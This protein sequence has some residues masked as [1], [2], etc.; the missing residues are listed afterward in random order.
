MFAMALP[1]PHAALEPV[2]RP[3]PA[4]GPGE[5]RLRVKACGVCRT[6]LHVVDDELGG[7]PMP[8]VPGHEIV[9]VVEAVGEGVSQDQIGHRLGVPWLGWTC[10]ETRST[11]MRRSGCRRCCRSSRRWSS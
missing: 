6:D 11:C 2:R 8:I 7:G 9:G 1:R 4:P 10:G 3:D 5:V